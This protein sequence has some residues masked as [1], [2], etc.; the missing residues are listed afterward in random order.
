[1]AELVRGVLDSKEHRNW[2][3]LYCV[4]GLRCAVAAALTEAFGSVADVLNAEA[5]LLAKAGLNE[6]QR[7]AIHDPDWRRV[8][9]WLEW[10]ASQMH[11]LITPSLPKLSS[12]AQEPY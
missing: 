7:Q 12:H 10:G 8:D 9:A 11:T 4:P 2:L 5:R 3:A 6:A 1:M